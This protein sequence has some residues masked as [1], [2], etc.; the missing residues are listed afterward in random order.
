[1]VSWEQ[2]KKRREKWGW[3]PRRPG[4][5]ANRQETLSDAYVDALLPEGSEYCVYDTW[6]ECEGLSLYVRVRVNGSKTYYVRQLGRGSKTVVRIGATHE[7]S[8]FEARGKVRQ[9]AQVLERGGSFSQF[10]PPARETVRDAFRRYPAGK[11]SESWR[12]RIERTFELHLLPKIGDITLKHVRLEDL[13]F[14]LSDCSTDYGKR[15]RRYI[16]SAFL[17]W[18]AKTNRIAVNPLKGMPALPR[19]LARR[20]AVDLG[21]FELEQIWDACSILPGKWPEI[22]RLTIATGKPIAQVLATRGMLKAHEVKQASRAASR[23]AEAYRI[24]IASGQDGYLFQARGKAEPLQFQS[25]VIAL[26]RHEVRWAGSFSIGDIVSGSNRHFTILREAKTQW[27]ELH[28]A[29]VRYIN[30]PLPDSEEVE[31]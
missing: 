22:I 10:G 25:R 3:E 4:R 15:Q 5:K 20:K 17:T 18:C 23:F 27:D 6:Q 26:L 30:P 21:R 28:P 11:E 2:R 13:N 29:T 8:I 31:I 19:P 7:T 9:I 16:L 24:S 1:M 14:A 12:K